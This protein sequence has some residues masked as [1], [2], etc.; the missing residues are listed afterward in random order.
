[1]TEDQGNASLASRQSMGG[2]MGEKGYSAQA[3]YIALKL[4]YWLIDG[5]VEQIMAEGAGDVDVL[6]RRGERAERQYLQVKDHLVTPGELRDVIQQ[7]VARDAADPGTYTRFIVVA[8]GFSEDILRLRTLLARVRGQTPMYA[9]TVAEVDTLADLEAA[10]EKLGLVVGGAWL[11]EKVELEDS[12]HIRTWPDSRAGAVN[13]FA[14]ALA[15]LPAYA[16]TLKPAL[17][18][19]F[20]AVRVHLADNTAQA[21]HRDALL[22]VIEKTVR[23]FHAEVEQAG[24][25]VFADHWGDPTYLASLE[26][27]VMFDWR[28]HFDRDTR[29]V[30]L[31]TIWDSEIVPE[32]RR[33]EQRLRAVQ[34]ARQV[35]VRGGGTLSMGVVLGQTFSKVRGYEVTIQQGPERWSS[36]AVPSPRPVLSTGPVLILEDPDGDGLCL[37]INASRVVGSKVNTFARA[38]GLTF[39]G[40]L[41]LDLHDEALRFDAASAVKAAQEIR[42]HLGRAL[43]RHDFRRV[44]LFYAGPFGL[45][46]LLGHLLNSV[47]DVCLYELQLEGGYARSATLNTA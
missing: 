29:R 33:T 9:G 4:P 12:A 17:A 43:D 46:V 47:D 21:L 36:A 5:A 11:L 7:F 20:D 10:V 32:L 30:P 39:Q 31:P 25:S 42:H 40:R 22:D 23:A 34:A 27:D 41:T 26:H 13:E 19:A 6:F 3:L 24:L 8:K 18:R 45:A 2:I 15:D 44:H 37:E 35:H 38:Q 16:K 14:G 1:M 28:V